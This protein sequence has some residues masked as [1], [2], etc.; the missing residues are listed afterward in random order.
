MHMGMDVGLLLGL[1]LGMCEEAPV[2][3]E[4]WR[5]GDDGRRLWSGKGVCLF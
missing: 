1:G 5:A 2:C 4:G 3:S